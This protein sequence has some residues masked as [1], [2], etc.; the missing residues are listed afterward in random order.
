MLEQIKDANWAFTKDLCMQL[1]KA[2][3]PSPEIADLAEKFMIIL[4][5]K[6]N[7]WKMF[8]VTDKLG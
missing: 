6:E 5:Q 1:G 2:K 8:Q 7:S 3:K 4:D